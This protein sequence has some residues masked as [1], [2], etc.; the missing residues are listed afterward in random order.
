VTA[1]SLADLERRGWRVVLPVEKT[2]ACG[3]VGMGALADSAVVVESVTGAL[4]GRG[5]ATKYFRTAWEGTGW[6]GGL[7]TGAVFGV[8]AVCT[9]RR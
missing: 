9:I 8:L 5:R 1:E 7:V 4:C 6:W 3:D 2:L